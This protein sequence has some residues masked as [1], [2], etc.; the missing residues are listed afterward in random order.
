MESP[1][2]LEESAFG[3]AAERQRAAAREYEASR[4]AE[5]EKQLS[6]GEKLAF[7]IAA[8]FSAVMLVVS[9]FLTVVG[10]IFSPITDT[11]IFGLLMGAFGTTSYVIWRGG[12][13]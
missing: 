12:R 6:A 7:G 11:L 5:K 2:T 3:V 8:A 13:K 1:L 9:L 10:F 4:E